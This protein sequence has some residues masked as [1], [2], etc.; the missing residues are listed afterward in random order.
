MITPIQQMSTNFSSPRRSRP[1]PTASAAKLLKNRVASRLELEYSD[2]LDQRDIALAVNEADALAAL[3]PFPALF[4]PTL[5]EEKTLQA[6]AWQ[7]KQNQLLSGFNQSA[8][9]E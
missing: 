5:A 9:S 2:Q 6:K 4:F 3:T 8:F 1:S 7:A